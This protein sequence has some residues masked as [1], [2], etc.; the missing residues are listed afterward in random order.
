M[1]AKASAKIVTNSEMSFSLS[2]FSWSP[3]LSATKHSALHI[4]KNVFLILSL[5]GYSVS[6]IK[7]KEQMD[8]VFEHLRTEF[9]PGCYVSD[10]LK[11]YTGDQAKMH[12][13]M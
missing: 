2:P 8:M 7:R 3:V 9:G 4:E 5:S 6:V 13:F 1:D 12:D 11:A 10:S